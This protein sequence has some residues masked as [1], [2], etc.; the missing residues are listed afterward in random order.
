MRSKEYLGHG[1]KGLY[2]NIEDI[3]DETTETGIDMRL[4][5]LGI[6]GG[7]KVYNIRILDK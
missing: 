7:I 4:S 2:E 3:E 5:E 6:S 1:R